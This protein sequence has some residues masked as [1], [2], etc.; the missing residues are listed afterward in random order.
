ME[1]INMVILLNPTFL[2]YFNAT[3]IIF[4]FSLSLAHWKPFLNQT[5]W[6]AFNRSYIAEY[7]VNEPSTFSHISLYVQNWNSIFSLL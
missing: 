1:F 3:I 2:I 4:P 5:P 6:A 7:F